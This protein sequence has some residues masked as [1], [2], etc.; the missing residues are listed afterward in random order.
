MAKP[1]NHIPGLSE[2]LQVY[3]DSRLLDLH[4]Y[5]PYHA[6]IMDGGFV[7]LDIWTTGRYYILTTDYDE[8][9]D[10]NVIERGGE[11]GQVPISSVEDLESFLDLIFFPGKGDADEQK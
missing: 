5:S 2:K 4:Q 1:K 7:V 10:G 9:T 6:R 8:M 3:A 11:K